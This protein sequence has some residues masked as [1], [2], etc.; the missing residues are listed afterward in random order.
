KKKITA[1]LEKEKL[2]QASVNY[3]LRDWLFSRQRYWGEPIPII[4]CKKCGTVPIPESEL[5]LKLPDMKDFKPTGTAEPPL[6]KAKDW[7]DAPCPKC[8]GPGMRETN[9]MPQWA[10]SCW[11]YL[12][13]L[14][15]ANKK[16]FCD[17]AKEKHWMPVDL[18]VGGAEHAVLHLLYSRFWH[19]VL[20]DLK[21][22]STPEPFMKLVN[23]GMILG[24]DGQKMSKSRGNV[25]NPDV[26]VQDY[27]AD[28]M[29]LYEMFMGP[30]IQMKAWSMK[31]VEGVYR[32]LGRVWRLYMDKEGN[33]DK[34]IADAPPGDSLKRLLHKTV[35][36]V[37]EDI[38][39][40]QF[41]TAISAMMIFSN[42]LAKEPVRP[43]SV[44][45]SFALILSPLAP[46]L[47]EELWEKLGHKKTLAYEKWPSYDPA[48]A[49]ELMI[50]IPIMINGKVKARVTVPADADEAFVEKEALKDEK[51]SAALQGKKILQ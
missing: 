8:K 23:Q 42:E 28:S 36:K 12:R 18:Y 48:F 3:K 22:V 50:E 11:Y 16:S 1:W 19:K 2:G 15:S 41:N 33:L 43:K 27:G 7:L 51:V 10:G 29:R 26:V 25:I 17:P 13:Y 24:E 34:S 46:H 37:T 40:L 49:E 44:M 30:L 20:Y 39:G 47:A 21:H 14:D 32:F 31:G 35:K 6:A 5:P 38:E 9:T 45:E 4:H